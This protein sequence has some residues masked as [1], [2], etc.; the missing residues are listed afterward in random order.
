MK[1]DYAQLKKEILSQIALTNEISTY[2][3]QNPP[4]DAIQKQIALAQLYNAL[5]Q[6][7]MAHSADVMCNRAEL[8]L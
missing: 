6:I 3:Y 1:I 2:T 7:D 4:T 8:G 5:A